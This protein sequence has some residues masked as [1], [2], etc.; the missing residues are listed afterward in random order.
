[1]RRKE[2]NPTGNFEPW[3]PAKLRELRQ[4]KISESLGQKLLFENKNIKVWEVVL[5]PKERLPFRK[6]SSN[7]NFVSMTDGLAVSHC[8]NGQICLLHF[9]KRQS[10][11]IAA[12]GK[13]CIYDLENIGK[14]ILFLHILEFKPLVEKM[15]SSDTLSFS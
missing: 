13:E 5:F 8:A 6:V 3:P 7:Y 1:M 15:D 14:N 2:V 4:N 9:K 11:F 10:E 12:E